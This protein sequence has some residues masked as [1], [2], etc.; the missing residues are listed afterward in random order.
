VLPLVY[1]F[2]FVGAPAFTIKQVLGCG[3]IAGVSVEHLTAEIALKN[4][5]TFLSLQ[6]D[7]FPS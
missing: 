4:D 3:E 7:L 6:H 1:V 5:L 2:I